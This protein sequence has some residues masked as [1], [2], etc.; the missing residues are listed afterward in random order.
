MT[1]GASRL[2]RSMAWRKPAPSCRRHRHPLDTA[3]AA[4]QPG[5]EVALVEPAPAPSTTTVKR[6]ARAA[7]GCRRRGHEQGD[8]RRDERHTHRFYAGQATGLR[9]AY[10]S[11]A[12][13]RGGCCR[14]A[15]ARMEAMGLIHVTVSCVN[16]LRASG[17]RR[18]CR[19]QPLTSGSRLP[20][21]ARGDQAPRADGLRVAD[22]STVEYDFAG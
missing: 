13:A 9:R 17:I 21:R 5:A 18:L 1:S 22:G 19:Y 3:G 14:T 15:E 12:T 6:G 16:R 2:P 8:E 11:R 4:H 7:A 20:T 10:E